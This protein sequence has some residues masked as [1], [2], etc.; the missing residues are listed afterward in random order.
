MK[1]IKLSLLLLL[2]VL[3]LPTQDTS[4][5]IPAG[6]F[7]SGVGRGVHTNW[8]GGASLGQATWYATEDC[9]AQAL[10]VLQALASMG[11]YAD[12]VIDPVPVSVEWTAQIEVKVYLR[13]RIIVPGPPEG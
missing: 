9:A 11:V 5:Q 3:A 10:P 13:W 8:N 6:Q 12:F 7:A 4:A 1:L 2:V